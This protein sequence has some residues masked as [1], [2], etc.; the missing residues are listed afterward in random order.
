MPDDAQLLAQ[1]KQLAG[2]TTAAEQTAV[3][4]FAAL[5]IANAIRDVGGKI[6]SAIT[7]KRSG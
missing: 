5:L 3:R 7:G 1:A 2:Q 4:I 6:A